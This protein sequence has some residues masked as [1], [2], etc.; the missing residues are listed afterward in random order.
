MDNAL[1]PTGAQDAA[2]REFWQF[3]WCVTPRDALSG[4]A[5]RVMAV[6][7]QSPPPAMIKSPLPPGD[8]NG[9][10]LC[11]INSIRYPTARGTFGF[12]PSLQVCS[13]WKLS[14]SRF[15]RLRLR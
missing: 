10:I 1:G 12:S 15:L 11:E 8:V 9:A 4:A 14:W 6:A 7:G 2:G 5:R 13:P 3:I